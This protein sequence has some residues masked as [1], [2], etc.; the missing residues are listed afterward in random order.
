MHAFSIESLSHQYQLMLKTQLSWIKQDCLIITSQTIAKDVIKSLVTA[1]HHLFIND[2]VENTLK[3]MWDIYSMSLDA[4]MMILSRLHL[5][6]ALVVTMTMTQHRVRNNCH[7]NKVRS[8]RSV[9]NRILKNA[10]R[11]KWEGWEWL[12]N[13]LRRHRWETRKATSASH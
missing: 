2:A 4:Q 12:D 13:D 1:S 3:I 7:A 9:V 10:E 11:E 8:K 5:A 6:H